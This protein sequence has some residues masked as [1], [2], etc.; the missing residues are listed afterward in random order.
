MP[1]F[2][3]VVVAHVL[4]GPSH[5]HRPTRFLYPHYITNPQIIPQQN[6]T[7]VYQRCNRCKIPNRCKIKLGV[8]GPPANMITWQ[9][10]FTENLYRQRQEARARGKRPWQSDKSDRSD[11]SDG[12]GTALRGTGLGCRSAAERRT[13]HRA[14]WQAPRRK[15]LTPAFGR[16]S[17]RGRG[18]LLLRSPRPLGE[19]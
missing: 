8:S 1:C 4:P 17:P 16:P 7:F 5:S 10:G 13:D 2:F 14:T 15:T 6:L 9:V 12:P 19:G 11:E 3:S 18:I